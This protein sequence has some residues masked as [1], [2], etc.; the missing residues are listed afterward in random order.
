MVVFL[1]NMFGRMCEVVIGSMVLLLVIMKWVLSELDVCLNDFLIIMLLSWK[2]D[3][4][5]I[6]LCSIFDGV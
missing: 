2:C 6:L 5:F 4:V 1:W 3:C